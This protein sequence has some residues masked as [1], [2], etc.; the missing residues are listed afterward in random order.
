V[1]RY[2]AAAALTAFL[3]VFTVPDLLFGL[4]QRSPFVQ[5]VSMR[6]WIVLA[7]AVLLAVLVVVTIFER[8]ALPFAAG[9]LA[10]VLVAGAIVLPRLV[11]DPV[12][13]GGA[14][15]RVL[16][17]NTYEGEADADEL[18]ALIQQQRPDVVAISESGQRYA[19]RLGPLIEPLGYEIHAT[20]ERR[21][22]D[23]NEVTAVVSDR[24]GDVD[25]RVGD[26]TS[27]FPYME[28]TGAGLG[29]L[30]VVVFHSVA[31]VPG[32]VPD[33]AHD[34]ALVKRWC[35]GSTP[36]IVAGDFNATLDHSL[37]RDATAGCG[38]AA[39]QRGAG[40]V[41]TWGPPRIRSFGPQIDHVFA[42][43]GI[44]AETF[45]VHDIAGSDHRAVLTTLR[46][47]G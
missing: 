8:R 2:L 12:P 31:P 33:W 10:L 9:V 32:S 6:P 34:V 20:G 3:A 15:L 4:D 38:D 17:F 24:L 19:E 40:L 1:A 36:T 25:V 11:P 5:L 23:I 43:D 29:D 39:A 28:L 22:D 21:D 14:P 45:D 13:A 18:A 44:V 41:P 7:D 35:A 16:A 26:E 30:R 37:L 27:T 47:P 46:L 42:T